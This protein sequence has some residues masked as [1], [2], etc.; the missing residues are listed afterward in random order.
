LTRHFRLIAALLI[1]PL[2]GVSAIAQNSAPSLEARRSGP[3]RIGVN[4][5]NSTGVTPE[6]T[7]EV[8]PIERSNVAGSVQAVISAPGVPAVPKGNI[9]LFGGTIQSVDHVRDRLVL[10]VFQGHKMPLLFDE[11]TQVFRDGKAASLDD[12]EAGQRAYVDSMLDGTDI[13]ARSIRIEKPS[14]GGQSS[15]QVVDYQPE[16]GELVLRDPITTETVKM[17]LAPGV[18]IQRGDHVTKASELTA[19]T[20]VSLAF[21][22]SANEPVVSEITILASPGEAYTFAGQVSAL[23]VTRGLLVLEDSARHK[24]YDLYFDP[25][26]RQLAS[27]LK[28]GANVTAKTQFDGKQYRVHDVIVTPAT[29]Q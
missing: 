4:S 29:I 12:V 24:S 27:Q 10:Q 25:N 6:V 15:G 11:R 3:E 7:P 19:G 23:D 16:S 17:R 18:A 2:S 1:A 21:T 9:S 22:P 5:S 20:L 13:F 14:G 28:L 8:S 26:A